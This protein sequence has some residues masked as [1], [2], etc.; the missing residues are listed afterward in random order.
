VGSLQFLHAQPAAVGLDVLDQPAGVALGVVL[1]QDRVDSARL[2]VEPPGQR[3]AG[4]DALH[5]DPAAG[6]IRAGRGVLDDVVKQGE[7]G[8]VGFELGERGGQLPVGVELLLRPLVVELDPLRLRPQRHPQDV[9]LFRA[10]RH[11]E[12]QRQKLVEQAG[13]SA[14]AV[15]VHF[16][17]RPLFLSLGRVGHQVTRDQPGIQK[18]RRQQARQDAD[19]NAPGDTDVGGRDEGDLA[20]AGLP[21]DVDGAGLPHF[22]PVRQVAGARG[23]LVPDERPDPRGQLVA[24]QQHAARRVFQHFG[25]PLDRDIDADAANVLRLYRLGHGRRPALGGLDRVLMLHQ[26][27]FVEFPLAAVGGQ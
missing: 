24:R 13:V 18:L 12:R 17:I 26:L 8:R 21:L 23:A 6:V 25:Q 7:P 1:R 20:V 27:R 10:G 11:V 2:A 14:L 5:F 16:D 9:R 4:L 22:E 3:H 15:G 19:R